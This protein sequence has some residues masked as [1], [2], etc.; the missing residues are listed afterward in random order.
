MFKQFKIPAL[1]TAALFA[2]QAQAVLFDQ[3]ITPGIIFGSGNTNGHFTVDKTG[4]VELG[5][6]AKIPFTGVLNSNGDGTYSYSFAE[7]DGA[8]P[9]TGSPAWN[10]EWTGNTNFDSSSGLVL[11]KLTYELGMDFDPSTATSFV[12]FDPINVATADHGIGTNSTANGAGDDDGA[13]TNAQY[14]AL[15]GANNVAQNSWRLPFFQTLSTL[16]YDPNVA[17]T[18]D[19][20]LK[21]F[22]GSTQVASTSIQ[23]LIAGGGGAPVP[24]PITL[25]LFGLGLAGLGFVRRKKP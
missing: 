17:G 1:V 12:A 3:N 13:R 5:L 21:A 24:E 9:H 16:T 2:G 22:N 18:Y 8:I 19:V 6:R 20:Y 25:A 23:V 15:I 4:G 10:F 11:D 7:Q 14:A